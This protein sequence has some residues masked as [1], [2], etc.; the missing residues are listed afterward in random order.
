M[1]SSAISALETATWQLPT[2]PSAPQY[3]RCTPTE[4][5]P[6]FGK[7]VSSIA[8]IPVRTGTAARSCVHTRSASQ[9]ESVMKCC[10]AWY[11]PGSLNRPC[12]ACIDFRSLSFSRPSR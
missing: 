5:V 2:L 12:I 9:G 4:S 8:R 10:R 3:W 1:R 6:C 7:P 11:W